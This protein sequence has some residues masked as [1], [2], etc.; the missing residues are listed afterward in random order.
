M[1]RNKIGSIPHDDRAMD[2]PMWDAP[3]FDWN[4]GWVALNSQ[5]VK[6]KNIPSAMHWPWDESKSIYVLHGFHSL[7][8]VVSSKFDIESN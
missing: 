5:E 3:E 4:V 6:N 1:P 2:D 7:H 8:C